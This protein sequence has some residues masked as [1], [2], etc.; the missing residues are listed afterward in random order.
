MVADAP[1]KIDKGQGAAA[2]AVLLLCSCPEDATRDL[3]RSAFEKVVEGA[4]FS[5]H[6]DPFHALNSSRKVELVGQWFLRPPEARSLDQ[7]PKPPQAVRLVVPQWC[8]DPEVERT[9]VGKGHYT[10]KAEQG[11]IIN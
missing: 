10:N 4:I 6:L 9:F 5:V 8:R 7:L 2:P 1:Q 11:V 3:G